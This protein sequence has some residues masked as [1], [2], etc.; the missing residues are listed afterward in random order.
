MKKLQRDKKYVR[1]ENRKEL[2]LGIIKI[3]KNKKKKLIKIS[4]K[5]N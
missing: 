5:K 3:Q 1:L 2:D 4:T